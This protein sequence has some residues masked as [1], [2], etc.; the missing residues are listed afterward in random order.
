MHVCTCTDFPLLSLTFHW[1][2]APRRVE[3]L[4]PLQRLCPGTWCVLWSLKEREGYR[5]AECERERSTGDL[6]EETQGRETCGRTSAQR[7]Q[8]FWPPCA[9]HSRLLCS[10]VFDVPFLGC[11]V[12]VLHLR[13]SS[14]S[15]TNSSRILYC[16]RNSSLESSFLLRI[17][18]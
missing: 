3:T 8:S 11:Q 2:R 13:V 4:A 9:S 5:R 15:I 18:L 6:W 7:A 10:L 1:N 12:P 16:F 14:T 17:P